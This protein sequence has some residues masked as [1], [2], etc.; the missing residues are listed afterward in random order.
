MLIEAG[1]YFHKG[2]LL[3]YVQ[4][5]RQDLRGSQPDEQRPQVGIGYYFLGHS[6]NLKMA[7]TRIDR[8][9]AKGRN[10]FQ[11]QYQAFIF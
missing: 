11:L 7:Y 9:G 8:D 6:S 2:R 5:A 1:Y 3:P 4:Y 10:Q